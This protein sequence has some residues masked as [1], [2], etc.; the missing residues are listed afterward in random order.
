MNKHV[1]LPIEVKI[2]HYPGQTEIAMTLQQEALYELSL[3]FCLLADGLVER[4]IVTNGQSHMTLHFSLEKNLSRFS[5]VT[6]EPERCFVIFASNQLEHARLFFLKYYRDGA[7]EV[8]H[9]HLE[10]TDSHTN[11]KNVDV[12]FV[13]PHFVQPLSADEAKKRLE[14]R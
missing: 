9:I 1:R 6:I 2:A 5:R 12:T 10:A 13:V 14:Q 11:A 7:A 4:L 3:C 8:N